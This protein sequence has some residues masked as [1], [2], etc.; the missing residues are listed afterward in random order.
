MKTTW[1][2]CRPS[3]RKLAIWFAAT[4][5]ASLILFACLFQVDTQASMLLLAAMS[6][7]IAF[8]GT[9]LV[10]TRFEYNNQTIRCRYFRT[11]ERSWREANSWSYFSHAG[12]I[13]LYIRFNDGMVVG[14][15]QW[16]LTRCEIMG[17]I[18]LLMEK[19]GEPERQHPILPS[20]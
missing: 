13:S 11:I 12:R 9:V 14:S 17:L 10:R 1:I 4:C 16:I 2:T 19:I 8:C 5:G 18:P 3:R 15:N 7:I 6:L 20:Q